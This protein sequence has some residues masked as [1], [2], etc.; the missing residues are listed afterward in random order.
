MPAPGLTW[1]LDALG[2]LASP[3][4]L[5]HLGTLPTPRFA[6]VLGC[7]RPRFCA[8]APH[9]GSQCSPATVRWLSGSGS[10]SAPILSF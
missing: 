3:G 5:P 4:H 1:G 8:R 2:D 10:C 6:C 9:V 7:G